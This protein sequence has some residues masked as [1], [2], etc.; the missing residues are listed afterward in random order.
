MCKCRGIE[1]YSAVSLAECAGESFE[2]KQGMIFIGAAGI[3]VRTIA[4]YL[5][6]KLHDPFVIVIDEGAG[7]VIPILSGHVGRA[8]E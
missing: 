2:K 5:K 7:Y 8:N 4:P 1:E 3:A 6:D